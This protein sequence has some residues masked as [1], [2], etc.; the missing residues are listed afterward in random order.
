MA[1]QNI[2]TRTDGRSHY[3]QAIVFDGVSYILHYEYNARDLHWY[4]SVHDSGDNPIEGLISRKVV[5]NWST[6]VRATAPGKPSGA[7]IASSQGHA[8]PG[9]T[10]LGESVLHHYVTQADLEALENG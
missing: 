7:I 3:N 1:I 9:L 6:L 4:V 10:D 8:D 2:P 5:V